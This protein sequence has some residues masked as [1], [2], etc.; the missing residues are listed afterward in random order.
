MGT[1]L[2][3]TD[4]LVGRSKR[5]RI[6]PGDGL[7]PIKYY[8]LW[9]LVGAGFFGVSLILLAS[10]LSLITRFYG[11]VV[12]PVVELGLDHG[13]DLLRP[14][15]G[16]LNWTSL[17]FLQLHPPK[18]RTALFVLSLFAGIF[19]LGGCRLGFGAGIFARPVRCWACFLFGL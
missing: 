10:P 12:F 4:R 14:V 2:D 16:K 3:G 11:L 6:P 1:T 15:A 5:R 18:F 17:M 13:A 7:R 19:A 9:F 8:V